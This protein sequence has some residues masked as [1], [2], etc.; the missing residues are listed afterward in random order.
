[1][2]YALDFDLYVP[3]ME[4]MSEITLQQKQ[5]FNNAG[6]FATG[7]RLGFNKE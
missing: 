1:M 3:T 4:S 6:A 7:K 2:L 5:L